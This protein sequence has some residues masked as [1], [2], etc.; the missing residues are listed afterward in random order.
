V[1]GQ[2]AQGNN[3]FQWQADNLPSGTYYYTMKAGSFH[4]TKAMVLLK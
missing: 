4:E 3:A 1:D 2:L